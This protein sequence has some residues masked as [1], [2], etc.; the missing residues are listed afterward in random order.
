MMNTTSSA[1]GA[2]VLLALW[3]AA[4]ARAQELPY[5]MWTGT[6]A[7]PGASAM[8]VTFEVGE[9]D[10]AVAIVMRSAMVEDDM[11]FRDVRIAGS[12]LTFWWEPGVRVD[13]ILS[14]TQAGGFEGS[15][16]GESGP[17]GE[18]RMTMVPPAGRTPS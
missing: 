1:L 13:C 4:P 9:T 12:E 2:A 6:I 5:G 15:C 17:E 8:P 11:P 7:P 10:G 18:G 3:A 16:V 14:R